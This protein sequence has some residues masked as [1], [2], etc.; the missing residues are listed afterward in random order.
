M[1][2]TPIKVLMAF[3]PAQEEKKYEI[4]FEVRKN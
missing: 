4:N 1:L 3:S 2:E